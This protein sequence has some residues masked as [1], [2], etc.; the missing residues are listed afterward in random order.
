MWLMGRTL[1]ECQLNVTKT[2]EALNKARFLINFEKSQLTPSQ[3]IKFLSFYFDS[4][5][6]TNYQG[7]RERK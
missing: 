5:S 1:E 2:Y 6:M 4:I 7:I 3:N